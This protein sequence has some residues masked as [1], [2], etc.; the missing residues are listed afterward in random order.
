MSDRTFRLIFDGKKGGLVKGS[1]PSSAA[2]KACKKLSAETGK[3]SFKFELQETTKDSKKNVYGPY[4]GCFVKDKIKVK[5]VGGRPKGQQM[6]NLNPYGE[7]PVYQEPYNTTPDKL[8]KY[9]PYS[10]LPR[11]SY[12]IFSNFEERRQEINSNLIT[13]PEKLKILRQKKANLEIEK[14]QNNMRN[15]PKTNK[16]YNNIKSI[17]KEIKNLTEFNDIVS[18]LNKLLEDYDRSNA[19]QENKNKFRNEVLELKSKIIYPNIWNKFDRDN[20]N[21]SNLSGLQKY[22]DDLRELFKGPLPHINNKSILTP[23]KL[24]NKIKET[25]KKIKVIQNNINL[26]A[27]LNSEGQQFS[28]LSNRVPSRQN[29]KST[30]GTAYNSL[31]TV[32]NID[33]AKKLGNAQ[34]RASEKAQSQARKEAR[35]AKSP[36]FNNS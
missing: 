23:K 13:R 21:N 8:K 15:I 10:I 16:I 22:L 26:Q 4:K 11:Q 18:N 34:Q 3:T 19:T 24:I 31:P 14:A 20:I 32:S 17:D 29:G 28:A 9:R 25:E 7:N 33:A 2:K 6:D 5:M 30:F 35:N 27:R 36:P 12:E 1:S